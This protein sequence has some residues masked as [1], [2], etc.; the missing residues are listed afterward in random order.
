M[1]QK[2]PKVAPGAIDG[3]KQKWYKPTQKTE[4]FHCHVCQKETSHTLLLGLANE[5]TDRVPQ[6]VYRCTI[7]GIIVIVGKKRNYPTGTNNVN[8][9]LYNMPGLEV[10]NLSGSLADKYN[11]K[12]F[13]DVGAGFGFA[14]DIAKHAYG[15]AAEGIE[16]TEAHEAAKRHFRAS[17]AQGYMDKKTTMSRKFDYIH[18]SEVLEHVP[19]PLEFLQ[20]IYS[21]LSRNGI[22]FLTTPWAGVVDPDNDSGVLIRNLSADDHIYLWNEAAVTKLLK[23][24]GFKKVYI[25]LR[26][27]HHLYILASKSARR[28]KFDLSVP[29]NSDKL[30]TYMLKRSKTAKSRIARLSMLTAAFFMANEKRNYKL[31]VKLLPKLVRS[32]KRSL[33]INLK[34]PSRATAKQ[35]EELG[36]YAPRIAALCYVIST[37]HILYTADYDKA[38]EYCELASRVIKSTKAGTGYGSYVSTLHGAV[39]DTLKVAKEHKK[40]AEK[41]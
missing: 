11:A 1:T 4:K 19:D 37:V 8:R 34:D 12:T 40:R 3:W 22:L 6:N 31:C 16:P 24:V 14:T 30:L 35:I 17:V 21:H 5:D 25:E 39:L 28:V 10:M 41:S 9:S 20:A 26:D 18:S 13:L 27:G 33:G 2:I 29:D 23:Q 32:T 38:I 7:C 36:D 15:L